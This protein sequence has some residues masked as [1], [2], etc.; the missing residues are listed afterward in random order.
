[1]ERKV[2]VSDLVGASEIARRLGAASP[3]TIHSWHRRYSDFPA[4]I[5][6]LER[7]LVWSWP[8]VQRWARRTG[9]I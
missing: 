5:T 7:A 3:Q 6:Q 9:R 1:M 4:P 2:R 8:D